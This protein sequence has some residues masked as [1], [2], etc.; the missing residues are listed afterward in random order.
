MADNI[1]HF[2]TKVCLCVKFVKT[3]EIWTSV[4]ANGNI[5][6]TNRVNWSGLPSFRSLWWRVS[7]FASSYRWF[8]RFHS[9]WS[10]IL[11]RGKFIADRLNNA[12]IIMFWMS[13]RILHDQG[14]EFENDLFKQN[15]KLC[16][17]RKL[18]T[19]PYHPQTNDLSGTYE[20]NYTINVAN[21]T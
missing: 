19:T 15:K 20:T 5:S 8:F 3:S 21:T 11:K 17:I 16:G 14:Q 4:D 7:V 6:C 2:F 9:S 1:S 10:N 18:C 12:F 13:E